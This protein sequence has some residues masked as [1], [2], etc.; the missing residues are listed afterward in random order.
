[1]DYPH[2]VPTRRLT[3]NQEQKKRNS[4]STLTCISLPQYTVIQLF[5]CYRKYSNIH[6]YFH[7]LDFKLLQQDSLIQ[8]H[9]RN[10]NNQIYKIRGEI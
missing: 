9:K 5:Y 6:C 7:F 1:M 8:M 4:T 3:C 2:K 10:M